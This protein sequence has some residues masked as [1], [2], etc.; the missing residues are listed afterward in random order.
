MASKL[1]KSDIFDLF[2][3]DTEQK[4][5][6]RMHLKTIMY[7]V[8]T[9]HKNKAVI[10]LTDKDFFHE[11][12]LEALNCFT[13]H[14]ELFQYFGREELESLLNAIRMRSVYG[15]AK[16]KTNSQMMEDIR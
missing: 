6:W 13:A 1:A 7:H 12:V 14:G 2:S 9:E 16:E 8:A 4:E 5:D 15:R 3:N 10:H 11:G